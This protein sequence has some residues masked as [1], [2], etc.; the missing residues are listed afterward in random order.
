MRTIFSIQNIIKKEKSPSIDDLELE[1]QLEKRATFDYI[2]NND[3]S[4]I[5]TDNLLENFSKSFISKIDKQKDVVFI[6]GNKNDLNY[7]SYSTGKTT[8]FCEFDLGVEN[9][10]EKNNIGEFSGTGSVTG[11]SLVCYVDEN[12]Y[13]FYVSDLRN[14]Y[15]LIRYEYSNE[16]YIISE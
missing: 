4:D 14:L 13:N 5:E 6:Y 1:L 15:Y 16:V 7:N 2:S 8:I 3:L 9:L 10:T 12:Q 11:D